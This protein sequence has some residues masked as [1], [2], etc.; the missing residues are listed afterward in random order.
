MI[1]CNI[2]Y[3][4]TVDGAQHMILFKDVAFQSMQSNTSSG[5]LD[6]V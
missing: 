6:I 4:I 1:L 2:G 5:T 3:C